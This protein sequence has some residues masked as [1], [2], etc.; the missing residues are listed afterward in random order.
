MPRLSPLLRRAGALA[1]PAALAA[2]VATA[3]GCASAPA[4]EAE[5]LA[6][7]LA[8]RPHVLVGEVHDKHAQLALRA[9]ALRLLR[10][11]GARPA[12]AFEQFDRDRQAVL[13][14]AR[15]AEPPAGTTRVDHLIEQ[16]GA[17]G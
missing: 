2:A 10:A 13:D 14:A 15:T 3:A 8:Q 4:L 1:A 7:A 5:T 17:R 11:G 6:A 16:A 12:L 9:Q